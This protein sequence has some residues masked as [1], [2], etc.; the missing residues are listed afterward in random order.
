MRFITVLTALIV[1]GACDRTPDPKPG[2]KPELQ[3]VIEG[4]TLT[5]EGSVKE[6]SGLTATEARRFLLPAV[7]M[8]DR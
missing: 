2:P 8:V 7:D 6:G 4:K 3:F 1:L 5:V